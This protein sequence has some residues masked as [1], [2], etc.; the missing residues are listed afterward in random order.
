M[1]ITRAMPMIEIETQ[2]TAGGVV[3]DSGQMHELPL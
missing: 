3:L 2:N 1:M